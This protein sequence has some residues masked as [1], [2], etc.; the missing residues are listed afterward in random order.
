MNFLFKD[1][2]DAH[3]IKPQ[4]PPSYDW[5]TEN[6]EADGIWDGS[7]FHPRAQRVYSE[8]SV[9][10]LLCYFLLIYILLWAVVF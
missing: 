9:C 2:Q 5:A 4:G 8:M 10:S 7:V 6:E 3:W 1:S